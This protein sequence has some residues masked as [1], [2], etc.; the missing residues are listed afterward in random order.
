MNNKLELT[1]SLSLL[2]L[3]CTSCMFKMTDLRTDTAKSKQDH[4][5]A[6]Q[7][8]Q[9]MGTAHG[10]EAWQ[11]LETYEVSFED[12]FYGFMGKQGNPFEESKTSMRLRYIPNS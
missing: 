10:I 7:L 6:R 5:K 9:E 11:G 1:I 12:E 2:L 8:L 4:A 3:L